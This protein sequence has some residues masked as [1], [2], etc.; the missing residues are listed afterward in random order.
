MRR[1]KSRLEAPT[2]AHPCGDRAN[3]AWPERR[4]RVE[5]HLIF[6]GGWIGNSLRPWAMTVLSGRVTAGALTRFA[7]GALLASVGDRHPLDPRPAV[8]ARHHAGRLPGA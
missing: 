6:V 1:H 7:R 3:Q 2:P 8:R 4:P 5:S